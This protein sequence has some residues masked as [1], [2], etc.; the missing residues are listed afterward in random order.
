MARVYR[1]WDIAFCAFGRVISTGQERPLEPEDALFLCH[2][3]APLPQSQKLG[4]SWQRRYETERI[5]FIG[6]AWEIHKNLLLRAGFFH[7]C[8]IGLGFVAPRL[9]QP[10]IDNLESSPSS[11]LVYAVA[12]ALAPIMVSLCNSQFDMISNRIGYRATGQEFCT[13]RPRGPLPFFHACESLVWTRLTVK[14]MRIAF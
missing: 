1:A 6:T 10:L 13:N 12:V 14:R 2:G 5:V 8:E 3:D 7:A 9:I 4:D 11:S